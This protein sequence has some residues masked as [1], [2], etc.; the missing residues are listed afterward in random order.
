[1]NSKAGGRDS[2]IVAR[3]L[4]RAAFVGDLPALESGRRYQL[5]TIGPTRQPQ[6]DLILEG[7]T[8]HA[9]ELRPPAADAIGLAISIEPSTVA[10]TPSAVQA[11]VR[12]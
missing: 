8:V 9:E 12:L 11:Q 7:G 3:S 1:L 4:N 6:P 5:W 2:F 10:I